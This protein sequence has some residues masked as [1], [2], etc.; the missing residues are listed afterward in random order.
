[1]VKTTSEIYNSLMENAGSTGYLGNRITETTLN[2]VIVNGEY[3]AVVFVKADDKCFIVI[4]KTTAYDKS[5]KTGLA[6]T[7][8][9]EWYEVSKDE[10]NE[11]YKRIR[12]TKKISKKGNEFYKFDF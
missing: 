7:H 5:Y 3:R 6:M 2:P 4:G 12:A 9:N 10:G 1:M 8:N 11:I